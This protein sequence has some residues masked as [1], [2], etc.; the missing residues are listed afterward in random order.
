M[1]IEHCNLQ[2]LTNEAYP[3]K[4]VGL[5]LGNAGYQDPVSNPLITQTT[6]GQHYK[7]DPIK[8][9]KVQ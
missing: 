2:W 6:W 3:N 4:S 9:L 5:V 1:Y 7:G 8:L